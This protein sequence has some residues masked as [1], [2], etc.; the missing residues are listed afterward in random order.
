MSKFDQDKR[1][2]Y[3]RGTLLILGIAI[4]FLVSCEVEPEKSA[5]PFAEETANAQR[6]IGQWVRPD[7]GYVLE[8]S[9]VRSN[10]RLDATYH[11]PRPINVET[12]ELRQDGEKIGVFIELRDTGYPGSYYE[13]IYS[14][15]DDLLVGNYFQAAQQTTYEVVFVRRR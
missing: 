2:Q 8:I 14:E 11:N 3:E 1:R 12:A 6:L 7:G 13:L 4:L 15:K 9:R 5:A 10:G